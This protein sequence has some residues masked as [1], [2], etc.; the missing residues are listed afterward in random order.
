MTDKQLTLGTLFTA[1]V[2]E[3][4]A[5]EM[6]K[7]RSTV[8]GLVKDMKNLEKASK[9]VADNTKKVE[10]EQK[11]GT[12]TVN[13][14]SKAMNSLLKSMKTVASYGGAALIIRGLTQAMTNGLSVIMEYDQGLKNLQAISGASNAQLEL[15][16]D[17]MEYVATITKFS[18]TELAE[19]MVL[20]TQSGFSAGESI[21]SL[22]A[23]TT[24][25]TGTLSTMLSTTDLMTTSIR[26]FGLEAVES[27]RVADIFAN[28]V[29]KS[30]ATIDKFRTAFNYVA[31]AA[32]QANVSIEEVSAGMMTLFNNGMRASS[33]GTGLR[34]VLARLV[35]PSSKLR[36][37]FDE[38]GIALDQ[39]TPKTHGLEKA[40]ENLAPVLIDNET[41]LVDM[42]KAYQLFGL[43]GAQAI[44]IL[45]K[46]INTGAFEEAIERVYEVGTSAEM[47]AK[48]QE[49]LA[50]RWKQ[51]KDRAGVLSV[52][53]GKRGVAGA[54][55]AVIDA[56]RLL[57]ALMIDFV[58]S[59]IGG[60]VTTI[61]LVTAAIYGLGIAGGVAAAALGPLLAGIMAFVG[62]VTAAVS[63]IAALGVAVVALTTAE[64]RLAETT[65]KEIETQLATASALQI[66]SA[67]LKKLE[68]KYAE[69]GRHVT[70][71]RAAIER[72]GV[73]YPE[74]QDKLNEFGNDFEAVHELLKTTEITAAAKAANLAVENIKRYHKAYVE[75]LK[76]LESTRA[77]YV[78]EQKAL[79]EVGAAE[80]SPAKQFKNETKT[81][82]N[83]AKTYQLYIKANYDSQRA[84]GLTLR[85]IKD[86]NGEKLREL[87]LTKEAIVYIATKAIPM[88]KQYARDIAYAEKA[89]TSKNLGAEKKVREAAFKSELKLLNAKLAL[90]EEV[91]KKEALLKKAQITDSENRANKEL[92]IDKELADKIYTNKDKEYKALAE[93]YAKLEEGNEK[94]KSAKFVEFQNKRKLLAL[95]HDTDV[96]KNALKVFKD[97]LKTQ[98][99]TEKATLKTKIKNAKAELTAVKDIAAKGAESV[100]AWEDMKLLQVKER[101][102]SE[103]GY[104]HQAILDS[105]KI[106]RDAAVHRLKI[107][108]EALKETEALWLAFPEA[109]A[110][111]FE[112][113]SL[114]VKKAEKAVDNTTQGMRNATKEVEH[115]RSAWDKIQKQT[116]DVIA[117]GITSG[118]ADI[119]KGAKTAE[120]A[121]KD[122]AISTIEW[123]G[124]VIVQ[125]A[126]LNA[127]KKA[128]W[129][130]SI[131]GG[132]MV[133][134]GGHSGMVVGGRPTFS[135]TIDPSIFDNA[136]RFH[137]G[138]ITAEEVPII[139]KKG[140]GIF[141]QEQM[142]ALAPVGGAPG[143]VS[144]NIINKT[145]TPIT[146]SQINTKFDSE[147]NRIL[148]VVLEAAATNKRNFRRNLQGVF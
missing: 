57:L 30:K 39:I 108:K 83:L 131:T 23:V 11:K 29:N 95:K 72:L 126:I 88:Y 142:K 117:T 33:V 50:V 132:G 100:S 80:T 114:K 119:A 9:S 55:G 65:E 19:G 90:T 94:T 120:E 67:N 127:L 22:D 47:S 138:G 106:K 145:G 84:Q 8:N 2:H 62:P 37:A 140:E 110:H 21:A 121:M 52:A 135:R 73:E 4:F 129:F 51:L 134:G 45:I 61:G 81:L 103:M 75:N 71:Y 109:F 125:T 25:A 113:A 13:K 122:F 48:Q 78:A 111:A 46:S 34:Q 38:Y 18:T 49:G 98:A 86:A 14:Y 139:A 123:L 41:G 137:T 115:L 17:K 24:L 28:A 70:A 79:G 16:G 92:A 42:A 31:S 64:Q 35:A 43:R 97:N 68:T 20:L 130:T 105:A 7:L 32:S 26:A 6:Q 60:T 66:H 1:K 147:N 76:V 146:R 148:D 5:K 53:V 141:T 112:T 104:E 96:A 128:E 58:N 59:D 93:K 10:K 56:G 82:D 36:A 40:L 15:M 116:P 74:L 3:S 133:T 144:V 91:H 87:G 136:P 124:R 12:V 89:K 54:M 118:L 99:K 44:S 63:A 102:A 77:R 27:G 85:A 69:G 143:E 107:E 101:L